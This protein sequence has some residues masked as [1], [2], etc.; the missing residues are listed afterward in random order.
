MHSGDQLLTFTR[1]MDS[2]VNVTDNILKNALFRRR[3]TVLS[4]ATIANLLQH[5]LLGN[6]VPSLYQGGT[7]APRWRN[8]KSHLKTKLAPPT[9]KHF[10]RLW[11]WVILYWFC[12]EFYTLSSSAKILTW[13]DKVT[14][15]L[16][17]C[18][19]LRHS[20]LHARRRLRHSSTA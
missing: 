17:V 11:T 16:K 19:F 8:H 12:S 6:F 10:P 3:H 20:A 9:L 18:P 5:Q 1:S 14:E 4:I 15:S 13:F 7:P 2:K